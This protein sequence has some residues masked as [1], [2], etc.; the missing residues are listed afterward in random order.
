MDFPGGSV[1]K[2]LPFNSGA[3]DSIF[4]Q[5]AKI[6]CAPQPKSQNKKQEQYCNKF[7]NDLKKWSIT[8]KTEEKKS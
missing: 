3:A 4:G 8:T 1:V 6:P 2:T 7:Q 5:G